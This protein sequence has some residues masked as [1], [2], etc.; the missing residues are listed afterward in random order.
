MNQEENG[1]KFRK[2]IEKLE[3]SALLKEL[4]STNRK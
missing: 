3:E 4:E 2:S 1:K